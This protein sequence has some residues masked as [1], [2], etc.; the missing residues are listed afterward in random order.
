MLESLSTLKYT[1]LLSAAYQGSLKLQI[2]R[3][4][5][6]EDQ[7]SGLPQTTSSINPFLRLKLQQLES[8]ICYY[9]TYVDGV[10]GLHKDNV[11]S[12]ED[13]RQETNLAKEIVDIK[14]LKRLIIMLGNKPIAEDMHDSI[15][16]SHKSLEETL[17]AIISHRLDNFAVL[18]MNPFI[19]MRKSAQEAV[20]LGQVAM[21]PADGC[22]ALIVT[23][24]S[25]MDI[26][27]DSRC[28]PGGIGHSLALEF[29][30]N[31]LRVFAT[32]RDRN[33]LS[34]LNQRGIETLS[35]EVDQDQSVLACR[36][37]VVSL[38]GE[39][40]LDYLVNNA[41]Q[42]YTVPALDVDI[43]EARKTFE[44]NFFGVIR[45]CKAFA[46]L[47]IKA[48]GT[49]VQ[50]GS[51]AGIIPYVFGSVYNA[52]K[53]ALHSFSDTLRAEL[54][55]FGVQVTT[56]ITGGVKSRIARLERVLPP[57][58]LYLP[59]SD[60]YA[61]R[62]T[63]SQSGAM[64]NEIYA[65]KV[66]TQILYGAAPWRWIWP[67]SKGPGRMKWIWEGNK[68]KVVYL[69]SA[70]WT[71]VGFFQMILS[72]MFNLWKLRRAFLEERKRGRR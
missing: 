63:H 20:E 2:A 39:K 15:W 40:G 23:H 34:D 62:V 10:T 11:I 7:M 5:S 52:S 19:T 55:P 68:A 43:D 16:S 56:I 67:W 49:I 3:T 41:G 58:S 46:P 25:F 57:N 50:I 21:I 33:T 32:A 72:R 53:A 60:D 45:M 64:P 35:L 37:E 44:T 22:W 28:S 51:I 36:D 9:K 38:L 24:A 17:T 61:R 12:A 18:D 31:G 14:S 54:A 6:Y 4:A 70:G 29:H 65:R 48:Q 59:I 26:P 30:R 1:S 69:L 8:N 42:N 47:L 71:W 13:Y 27:L 66:V